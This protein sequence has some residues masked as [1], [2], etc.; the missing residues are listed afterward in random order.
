LGKHE[1][2]KENYPDCLSPLKEVPAKKVS[3]KTRGLYLYTSGTTGDVKVV[4]LSHENLLYQGLTHIKH[5]NF[6]KTSKILN[7]MPLT[8]IDGMVSGVLLSFLSHSTMVRGENFAIN[9]MMDIM[10]LIYNHNVTHMICVPTI[11]SLLL[12]YGKKE[13]EEAFREADQ[14]KFIISTGGP[15]SVALWNDFEKTTKKIVVNNYGMTE[16]G[17]TF[18]TNPTI[19]KREKPSV[20]R[21]IFGDAQVVDESYEK[22]D[23]GNIGELLF[24]APTMMDNYLKGGAPFIEKYGMK[25]F[26]TGDLAKINEQGH[27]EIVGRKKNIIISGGRNIYPE[28][29]NNILQEEEGIVECETFSVPD[30]NWGER[31]VAS[32]I[33]KKETSLT[34]EGLMGILSEKL[35]SYKVPRELIIL[36]EFPKNRSGKIDL[37]KLKDIYL[38]NEDHLNKEGKICEKVLQI[39]AKTFRINANKLDR[40]KLSQNIPGWDSMAHLDLITKTEKAFDLQISG[41]QAMDIKTLNDLMNLVEEKITVS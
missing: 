35:S 29:I 31:S 2:A 22:L 34:R 9:N 36:D 28:E 8:H 38:K 24:S 39:A 26:P 7:M 6:N 4:P 23:F 10:E 5:C 19:G 33:L 21:C 37:E 1:S 3:L 20:G 18:F 17:S 41:H 12:S 30:K 15:L 14:F 11:L 25:W 16:I 13:L 32:I 40:N 27:F